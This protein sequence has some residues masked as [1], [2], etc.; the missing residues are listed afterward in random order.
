MRRIRT[1]VLCATLLSP[2]LALAAIG[3]ITVLEGK[4][5]RTPESGPAVALKVG[6]DVE[7]KDTLQIDGGNA[8]LQLND[9][10]VI[11]IAKGSTLVIDEASFEGQERKGFAAKLKL[12]KIWAKVT[13]S[14]GSAKFEVTTERAVA[15]VRGTVFRIDT[16][17]LVN[18][19]ASR[20]KAKPKPKQ[21]TVVSVS[22]G[23]VDVTAKIKRAAPAQ[24]PKP[25]GPRQE[26]PPPFKEITA[27]EWEERFVQLKANMRV[28]VGEDLWEEASYS[29]EQDNDAFASFIQTQQ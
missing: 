1:A 7:L 6:S 19:A 4:G 29:P 12:G 14:L 9:E 10:S 2:A 15:G 20:G 13:K 11:L 21:R 8:K 25:K 5:T 17:T 27:D 26:I 16:D 23:L 22:E 24:P 18:A 28:T 3:K